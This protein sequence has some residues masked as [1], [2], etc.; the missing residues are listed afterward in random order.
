M[1]T[2]FASQRDSC[3]LNCRQLTR[4]VNRP[5]V[6]V[7]TPSMQ[8]PRIDGIRIRQGLTI[9]WRRALGIVVER[10]GS[11]DET[12][13]CAASRMFRC[14]GEEQKLRAWKAGGS[15][16]SGSGLECCGV[17]GQDA[18][19]GRGR[20]WGKR[21]QKNYRPRKGTATRRNQPK[22]P[23]REEGSV[24][25]DR[26]EDRSE[27]VGERKKRRRRRLEVGLQVVAGGCWWLL[28]VVTGKSRK[29]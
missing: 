13:E 20:N 8:K 22:K 14:R 25:R 1:S 18:S 16:A 21:K 28:P 4:V 29:E 19:R 6:A 17:R 23:R 2:S 11:C 7:G 10:G 9:D 5:R 27:A 15:R 24:C 12:L 26:G 3:E